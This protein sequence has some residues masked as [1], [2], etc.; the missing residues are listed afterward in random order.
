MD[1]SEIR[2][3]NLRNNKK[4]QSAVRTILTEIGEDPNR[5]GLEAT[6]FRVAKAY[7]EWFGGYGK[8]PS[9][10]L[11]R[12]FTES[13]QL[14]IEG[15]IQFYSHCEH[16]TAPFFG[17]VWIG[18]IP[19]KYVTGLDKMVKLVEIFARRLQIQER[20][21]QQIADAMMKELKC[22]GVMVVC[23]ATHFCVGSRETKNQ[24]TQTITSEVRG[25]FK[26]ND[27]LRQEFLSLIGGLK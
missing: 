1:M 4:I 27:I 22:G 26:T 23:K 18:Y 8:E 13:S 7:E 10:V 12:S 20:L 21:T 3:K 24:T 6:P 17:S 9:E 14:V 2:I 19:K 5:E 11:N 16:H 25:L 15:P